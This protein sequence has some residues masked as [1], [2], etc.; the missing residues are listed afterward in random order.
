[1]SPDDGTAVPPVDL[2][3]FLAAFQRDMGIDDV[4]GDDDGLAG[5]GTFGWF[6][7]APGR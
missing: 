6:P 1:M 2:A 7:G 5:G 4:E 3:P